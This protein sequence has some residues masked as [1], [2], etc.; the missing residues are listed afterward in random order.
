MPQKHQ[1]IP[2]TYDAWRLGYRHTSM[3][4]PYLSYLLKN[5]VYIISL[6]PIYDSYAALHITHRDQ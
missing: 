5:M 3:L 2:L 1:P 6:L 4:C